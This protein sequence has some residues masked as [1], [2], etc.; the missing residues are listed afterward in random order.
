MPY[1]AN[2]RLIAELSSP[3]INMRWFLYAMG[4]QKNS[5]QFLING[6]TMTLI[7]F[8]VRILTIPIYWY[9]VYTVM[10]SPLWI[11]MGYFR[12]VMVTT[13]LTL[14]II[15]LYWFK[16]IYIGAKYLVMSNGGRKEIQ[17]SILPFIRNKCTSVVDSLNQFTKT[18]S[19]K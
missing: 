1:F 13:C 5:F 17:K 12:L 14:D 10:E 7:F 16:K 18:F 3:I 11:V 2:F 4:Y 6:L 8:L 15:N 9:K 19:R